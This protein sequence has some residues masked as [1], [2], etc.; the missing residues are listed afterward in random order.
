LE[1]IMTIV[2]FI[3]MFIAGMG[4]GSTLTIL[5]SLKIQEVMDERAHARAIKNI[6]EA[7]M[8]PTILSYEKN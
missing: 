6:T 4:A 8:E 1:I 7:G 5:A 3:A 2:A